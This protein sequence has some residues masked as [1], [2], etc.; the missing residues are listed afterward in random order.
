MRHNLNYGRYA[1]SQKCPT[2]FHVQGGKISHFVLDISWKEKIKT[3]T[4]LQGQR[5]R[6]TQYTRLPSA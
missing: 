1:I 4:M 6:K 5:Q 2:N 3:K